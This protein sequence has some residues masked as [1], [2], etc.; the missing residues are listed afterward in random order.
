MSLLALVVI[1]CLYIDFMSVPCEWASSWMFYVSND[2]T[3]ALSALNYN[4]NDSNLWKRIKWG[5]NN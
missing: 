2:S 3:I 1:A 4:D 5:K